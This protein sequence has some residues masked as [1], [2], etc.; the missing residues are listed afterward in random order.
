MSIFV[1][2]E[3]ASLNVN[4]FNV[5]QHAHRNA[6]IERLKI[7]ALEIREDELISAEYY[8][9]EPRQL[10][11]WDELARVEHELMEGVA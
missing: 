11:L 4:V 3:S 7:R 6:R 2:R 8:D 5:L 1:P 10:E 9:D